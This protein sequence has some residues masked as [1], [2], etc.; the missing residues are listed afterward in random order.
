MATDTIVVFMT[1]N[2]IAIVCIL[3]IIR[4]YNKMIAGLALLMYG[5]G[6]T[7][8]APGLS[9]Y[10]AGMAPATIIIIF[11]GLEEALRHAWGKI[12]GGH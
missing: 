11:I 6:L 2:I 10:G 5:I 9:D 7:I 8:V 1:V 4:P 12:K 3:A